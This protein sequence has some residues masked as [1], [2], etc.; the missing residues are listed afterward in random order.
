VPLSHGVHTMKYVAHAQQEKDYV[1]MP[2]QVCFII[3]TSMV[4]KQR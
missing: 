4:Y 2:R 1:P 3:F